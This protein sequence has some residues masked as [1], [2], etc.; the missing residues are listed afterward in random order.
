MELPER[1]IEVLQLLSRNGIMTNEQ[2][3]LIYGNTSKYYLRRLEKLSKWGYIV[4]KSGHISI[5]QKGIQLVG[6][7][8][9]TFKI[10]E[11]NK[12]QRA[13]LINL[14][15]ELPDWEIMFSKEVKLER[16]INRGA[17]IGAHIKK[18]EIEYG[19]YMLAAGNP[20]PVTVG[21]LW[22]EINELPAKSLIQRA[23][24]F[25][26][27]VQSMGAMINKIE[28]PSVRELL[29]LPYPNGLEVFKRY[30]SDGFRKL[31]AQRFPGPSPSGRKFADFIWDGK[32]VS[33][34][35]ANDAVK[36]ANLK[37]YYGGLSEELEKREVIIVC[38]QGQ[39][40]VFSKHF[41]HAK[42]ALL[43]NNKDEFI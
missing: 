24:I 21:R 22:R 26:Y 14:V 20:R 3:R 7:K 13:D 42:F 16:G 36:R 2:V 8:F 31:I 41:P 11:Q 9:S 28:D 1:D 6:G 43:H 17:W 39:H 37:K 5:T 19:V 29:M 10:K 27:S 40:G 18:G 12:T 25:C 23:I 38:S 35:M 4:R 15:F 34:L 30:H 33:I 32:Y